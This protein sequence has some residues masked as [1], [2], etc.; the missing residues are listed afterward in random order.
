MQSLAAVAIALLIGVSTL[1]AVRL[2][3]LHRRTGAWPEFLLGGMLLLSLGVGYPLNI[4][5]YQVGPGW[6]GVL[7]A[8]ASITV[9]VGFSLLFVFTWRVFRPQAT[10]ARV[11]TAAGV[12]IL[13]GKGLHGAFQALHR[14]V[15]DMIELP[16]VEILLQT[17][18][19]VVAYFWTACESLRYYA[20]MRRRARLGLADAVVTNRF[21]VWGVMGL[22]ATGGVTL[23]IVAVLL[24][25][26][27]LTSPWI[28][29]PSA[30]LGFAEATFL[31]LAFVPPRSYLAW[32]RAR[33]AAAA[34]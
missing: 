28:L 20:V 32:V 34:D 29:L 13:L 22:C 9:A 14:G 24:H 12:V 19:L 31:T 23:N 3:L 27:A 15:V 25:V 6:S 5:T 10:W 8:A 2:L 17:V 1:V 16:P 18:P 11:L 33:A 4:A 21:L 30:L 26:D 7:L